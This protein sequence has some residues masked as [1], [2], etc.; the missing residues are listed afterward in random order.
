M[1]KISSIVLEAMDFH[2][3]Y[4]KILG[5]E[6][7]AT[8]AEI[9]LAY[10]RLAIRYH[11]DRNP[12]KPEYEEV[13]KEL[14]EAKEVLLDEEQRFAYDEY[15]RNTTTQ[16]TPT[17]DT[18]EQQ[19]HDHPITRTRKAVREIRI[20]ITGTIFIKYAAPQDTERF[21]PSLRESYYLIRATEV[22]TT[23]DKQDCIWAEAHPSSFAEIFNSYPLFPLNIPQP[24]TTL[25]LDGEVQTHYSLWI[26]E[27]R[28][29]DPQ[30]ILV[31][32][33]ENQSYG[34]LSGKFYGYVKDLE[35]YEITET[36]EKE[37]TQPFSFSGPTGR[38][39]EKFENGETFV[40]TEYFYSN[41]STFK[42]TW[43]R[44][45]TAQWKNSRYGNSTRPPTNGGCANSAG[46][47]ILGIFMLV[48]VII[49]APYILPLILFYA[50][51]VLLS[52]LFSGRNGK[53]GSIAGALVFA[54][55]LIG[56]IWTLVNQ[57]RSTHSEPPIRTETA[58]ETQ[59]PKKE[60]FKDT[61]SS[62][63]TPDTLVTL[64]REW[65]DYDGNMYSGTYTYRS[66]QLQTSQAFK[67][68]MPQVNATPTNYDR[69]IHTLKE[70]DAPYMTGVYQLFDSL[71]LARKL[72]DNAFA[73]MI[74]SFVQDI[75]YSIVL[76][77]D[78]DPSLYNDAFISN[79]LSSPGAICEPYQRFGIYSPL[80]FIANG[81]GDCDT[82]TLFCYLVFSHYG[83]DVAL[84]SSEAYKHSLIAI[85]LP[86]SG[87]AYEF[88]QNRYVVWETTA[89][90]ARPGILEHDIS[91]MRA[92]RIS[93]LNQP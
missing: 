61:G 13:T 34:T 83:Y 1:K 82:R 92:W 57:R 77:R 76:D 17:P 91:N 74:V 47:G 63:K 20:Y 56:M 71:R 67:R 3:D 38:T 39:E 85:N 40:K 41:G 6:E 33:H 30:I 84:L 43:Q 44:R 7:T 8:T 55:F 58:R 37:Y 70:N 87:T 66:S 89:P 54:L 19:N 16:S 78:C 25:M 69:I 32:K 9:R 22:S 21:D 28:I 80:E 35:E 79:Y 23:I 42:G 36:V 4:Y 48:W 24:I 50:L 73:E 31:T 12:G 68:D 27:L 29:P 60:T 15:R 26:R 45:K 75:P 10:R 86:Y 93:L 14:N 65:T 11:P 52:H 64:F 53:G 18:R 46:G 90:H 2:K 72:S 5:V 49:Q 81:N 51:L 62:Y 59:A 88:R